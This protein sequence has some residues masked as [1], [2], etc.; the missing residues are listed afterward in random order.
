MEAVF[1]PPC[2]NKNGDISADGNYTPANII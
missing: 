2:K 1:L